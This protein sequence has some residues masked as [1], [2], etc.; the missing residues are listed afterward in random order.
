MDTNH[1]NNKRKSQN[2]Q[3]AVPD[4]LQ[5]DNM[6]EGILAKM[7]ELESEASSLETAKRSVWKWWLMGALVLLTGLIVLLS[8]ENNLIPTAPV[9]A[10]HERMTPEAGS[11]PSDTPIVPAIAP[12]SSPPESSTGIS[13]PGEVVES[14][15]PTATI[16]SSDNARATTT[17]REAQT[18]ETIDSPAENLGTSP[19]QRWRENQSQKNG[20]PL[21][22]PNREEEATQ[23]FTKVAPIDLSVAPLTISPIQA[24]ATESSKLGAKPASP[25][26]AAPKLTIPGASISL[27]TGVVIWYKAD[28]LPEDAQE[29]AL[30]SVFAQLDYRKTFAGHWTWS[31]GIQYQELYSRFNWNTQIND[32]SVT[33]T[34]TIIRVIT[35]RTTGEQQLIRGDVTLETTASR[36][37]Q[38][39]NRTRIVQIPFSL[40][41]KWQYQRWIVDLALG[42]AI[43][44]RTEHKGR[45]LSAETIVDFSGSNTPLW[46]NQWGLSAVLR[47]QVSYPLSAQWRVSTQLQ[48]QQS[49]TNWS[50]LQD[51]LQRPSL[52]QFGLG[53]DY[54]F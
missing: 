32:F 38:H 12:M 17:R 28:Q 26:A 46:D 41:R 39:Y 13:Q 53:L 16:K 3:P 27:H 10:D 24:L 2:G 9:S 31:A 25:L 18:V 36:R 15:S 8:P 35:N 49:I 47:G 20:S 4:Y 19:V 37:V 48:Y 5:W 43:N 51:Q 52:L 40:G 42:G 34:D 33:L 50:A 54:A 45:G 23:A 14:K 7:D 44:V 21:T 30:P 1:S 22:A 6:K 29:V 11:L